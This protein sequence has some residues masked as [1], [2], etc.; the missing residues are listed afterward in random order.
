MRAWL[1]SLHFGYEQETKM[2]TTE[3]EICMQQRKLICSV[4]AT[5]TH[6]YQHILVSRKKSVCPLKAMEDALSVF[7]NFER[8]N[9]SA[10]I[11]CLC[12]ILNKV[13]WIRI[14]YGFSS[15]VFSKLPHFYLLKYYALPCSNAYEELLTNYKYDEHDNLY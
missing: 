2:E 5:H 10:T 9:K 8:R 4:S 11:F 14:I 12:A 13:A 7:V 6:T 1:L 15:R 3:E